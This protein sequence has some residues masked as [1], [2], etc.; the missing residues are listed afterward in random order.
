MLKKLFAGSL[1]ALM[2]GGLVAGAS[3]RTAQKTTLTTG[4]G[5]QGRQADVVNTEDAVH[6]ENAAAAP[7][8]EGQGN[9]GGRGSGN[10]QGN[11]GGRGSGNGQNQDG[12]QDQGDAAA[13]EPI[14]TLDTLTTSGVIT[15]AN[16]ETLVVDTPDGPIIIEGRAWSYAQ[17]QAF[18]PDVGARLSLAGF[19][20]DGEFKVTWLADTATG[21]RLTLRDASGRPAWAGRN[22]SGG[23]A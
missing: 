7:Q 8:G 14:E 19:Y 3:N 2:I 5:G 12:G 4:E 15:T 22:G 20:E 13:V 21:Q 10:G 6:A 1:L 18:L 11:G 16:E 23:S 17:Q 9:G